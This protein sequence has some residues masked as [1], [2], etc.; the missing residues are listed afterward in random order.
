MHPPAAAMPASLQL[1]SSDPKVWVLDDAMSP[2]FLDVVDAAFQCRDRGQKAVQKQGGRVLMTRNIHF[3]VEELS[4]ELFQ[5]ISSVCGL[6]EAVPQHPHFLVTE[7]CGQRQVAHV[8]HVNLDSIAAGRF[9]DFL[10]L[11]RQSSSGSNPRSVVP[12]VSIILYFNAVGGVRFPSAQGA[13]LIAGKRGRM[14]L[15]EN[16]DDGCRPSHKSSSTHYGVYFETLPKR[17]L[18]MGVLA[19]ETPPM[20]KVAEPTRGLIYCAGTGRDPLFHGNYPSHDDE[21]TPT[22]PKPAPKPDLIVSLEATLDAQTCLVVG[23]S[24]AGTDL[25]RVQCSKHNTLG[26]LR[27]EVRRAVDPGNSSN[28]VLCNVEGGLLTSEYNRRKLSQCFGNTEEDTTVAP[29]SAGCTRFP[30]SLV[31]LWHRW[32]PR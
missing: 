9:A 13:D 12:T 8:D 2:K 22:P 1:V 25:C 28:V 7:V 24:M 30:E 16:Y 15:F 14:I 4:C 26:F 19:N 31:A 5:T 11:T 20:N 6:K 3:E 23:R 29:C 27:D 17:V 10:D 32:W 21:R 18:V